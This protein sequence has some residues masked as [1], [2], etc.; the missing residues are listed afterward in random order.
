MTK[1]ACQVDPDNFKY[2]TPGPDLRSFSFILAVAGL[3]KG[4]S[5]CTDILRTY[6]LCTEIIRIIGTD[7]ASYVFENDENCPF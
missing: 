3:I 7:T 6:E 4:K 1:S 2:S 5:G